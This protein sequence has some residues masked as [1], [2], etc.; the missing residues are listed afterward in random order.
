MSIITGRDAAVMLIEAL[1]L[2]HQKV[3]RIE[4]DAPVVGAATCRVTHL[5]T[6]EQ[7]DAVADAI[8]RT[9]IETFVIATQEGP[10][11]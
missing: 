8:R 4:I 9:K 7:V 6:E 5:M 2:Q 3:T 10:P 1:G 11:K